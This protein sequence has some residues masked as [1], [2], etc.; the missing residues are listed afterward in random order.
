MNHHSDIDLD[1]MATTIIV[2]GKRLAEEIDRELRDDQ[3][4]GRAEALVR[5]LDD[6]DLFA[7]GCYAVMN[8]MMLVLIT[9]SHEEGRREGRHEA[10]SG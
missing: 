2:R 9:T 6:R 7:V 4:N 8:K 3:D 1:R 10:T 5:A